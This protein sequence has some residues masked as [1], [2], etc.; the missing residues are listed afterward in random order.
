MKTSTIVAVILLM[1]GAGQP[2]LV[3]SE[4]K[5]KTFNVSTPGGL[6]DAAKYA[7]FG[8]SIEIQKG[9]KLDLKNTSLNIR[10]GVNI[11][12]GGG[13]N[14]ENGALLMVS[15]SY[16]SKLFNIMGSKVRIY[17]LRIQGPNSGTSKKPESTGIDTD[18]A[19]N[20]LVENCDIFGWSYAGIALKS[21][22]DVKI[23]NNHIHHNRSTGLGYG[24]V[25]V[26]NTNAL[27][28]HNHFDNNRHSIAGSEPTAS[29]EA[30]NNIVGDVGS[31]TE[32]SFDMHGTGTNHNGGTAGHTVLIHHNTFYGTLHSAVGIRGKPINRAEIYENKFRGEKPTDYFVKLTSGNCATPR[33]T[34]Y[35]CGTSGHFCVRDNTY[36]GIKVNGNEY[37]C[38]VTG[39]GD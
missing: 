9:K 23:L 33:P 18:N 16:K 36:K 37:G 32:H 13:I 8:D 20:L 4:P 2:D 31:D 3:R 25:V 39:R 17:G 14:G 27:I 12:G 22:R 15:P 38:R 7:Q 19:D 35:Q 6:V 24:I 21:A 26:K 5:Y 10:G 29:Y 28:D 30:S 34:V 11:Y 1:F